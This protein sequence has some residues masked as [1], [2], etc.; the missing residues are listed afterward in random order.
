[1]EL[2]D[3]ARLALQAALISPREARSLLASHDASVEA[4]RSLLPEFCIPHADLWKT[5]A[6]NIIA[7]T[8][9][10]LI[11]I[12]RSQTANPN[13]SYELYLY[14]NNGRILNAVNALRKIDTLGT[15]L[16]IGSAAGSF[17]LALQRLGYSVTAVDR[18]NFP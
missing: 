4:C 7:Q 6:A 15:V 13:R 17:S 16:E 18:Y 10:E 5:G 1:M 3:L 14:M 9:A 11:D 8:S 12:Y 2:A